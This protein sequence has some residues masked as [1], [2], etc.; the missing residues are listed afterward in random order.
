VESGFTDKTNENDR[1]Y[2]KRSF[3]TFES[4]GVLQN[5]EAFSFSTV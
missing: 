2:K 1:L 4:L 5:T 3:C